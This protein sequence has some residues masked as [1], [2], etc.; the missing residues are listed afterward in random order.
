MGWEYARFPNP[1]AGSNAG[2][3]RRTAGL[4]PGETIPAGLF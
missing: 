3:R 2:Q 1:G 4:H